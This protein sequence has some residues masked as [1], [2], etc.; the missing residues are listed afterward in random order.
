MIQVVLW[1]LDGTLVDSGPGITESVA[2]ALRHYG[3][4][5]E[6]PAVLRQ[7]VGPP[8]ADAFREKYGFDEETCRETIRYF[9]E[10]YRSRGIH[11][12]TV[13]PGI[14]ETLAVLRKKN[15]RNWVA[16]SKPEPFAIQ[17]LKEQ[18]LFSEFERIAGADIGEKHCQKSGIIRRLL[19]LEN[20]F[21]PSE[22]RMVG[23]R[24]FD[25]IGAAENRL[26]T[27]G[28]LYGYGSRKELQKAGAEI[29]IETPEELP[30]VLASL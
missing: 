5:E 6:N 11:H 21:R 15:I 10:Y 8:L 4:V 18:Q 30:G 29:L 1:D 14:R 19:S 28:V 25:V 20:D 2:Y 27:I 9:Q 13:Y 23:D 7:F 17:V 12:T 26:S 16:T 24:C 22:M 3:I